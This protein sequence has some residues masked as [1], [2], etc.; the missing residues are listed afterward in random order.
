MTFEVRVTGLRPGQLEAR[1]GEA[2][3]V[4]M[5]RGA[6]RLEAEVK[7]RTPVDLGTARNSVHTTLPYGHGMD[8]TAEVGSGLEYIAPLETGRRPGRRPPAEALRPWVERNLGLRGTA[9][10]QAAFLLARKIGLKGT[11]GAHMFEEGLKAA[12][13]HIL[14]EIR[15]ALRVEG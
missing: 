6:L 2:L 3:R 10:G 5:A 12:E 14:A 1:L 11:D 7:T 15:G 13:P 9:A 4:G 8:L